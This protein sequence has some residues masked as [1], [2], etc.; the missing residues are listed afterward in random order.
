MRVIHS[1]SFKRSFANAS[2]AIALGII[3]VVWPSRALDYMVKVI[4]VAFC[5]AGVV[6]L[7]LHDR[8]RGSRLLLASGAGSIVLGVLLW[9]F[10]SQ[11]TGALVYLLGVVLVVAGAWQL[12]LLLIARRGGS[13]P[14]GVY[15]FPLVTLAAGV[16]VLANPFEARETIVIIFG[17]TSIITG[18]SALVNHRVLNKKRT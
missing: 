14:G 9:L 12:S 4:G 16:M 18:V 11:F 13:V 6:A 15:L 5:V 10:S 3:L 7:L 8:E 1:T 2:I 17:V